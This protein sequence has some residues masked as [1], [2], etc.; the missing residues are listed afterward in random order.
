MKKLLSTILSLTLLFALSVPA[1]AAEQPTT[2]PAPAITVD[3]DNIDLTQPYSDTTVVYTDDNTPVTLTMEFTP[4]PQTR[5]SST[6]DASVGT[7]TSHYNDPI[8]SMSYEFDLEKSG[9]QWKMTNARSHSYSGVLMSFSN[10]S[11]KISRSVYPPTPF[12]A[13]LTLLCS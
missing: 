13:K 10:P 9:S 4:A 5:G 12:L 11:L 8:S 2:T 1:F 7:W 6:N 3:L